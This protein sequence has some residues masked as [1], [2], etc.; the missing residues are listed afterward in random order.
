MKWVNF[1]TYDLLK[2]NKENIENLNKSIIMKHK[3]ADSQWS[4]EGGEGK[5]AGVRN[6]GGM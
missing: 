4:R 3:E 6:D 1:Q 2:L 5:G